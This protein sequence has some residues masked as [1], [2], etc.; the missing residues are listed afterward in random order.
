M[1]TTLKY[2]SP[3]Y[4]ANLNSMHKRLIRFPLIISNF[5]E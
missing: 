2:K 1:Y 5:V 3:Q 4:I